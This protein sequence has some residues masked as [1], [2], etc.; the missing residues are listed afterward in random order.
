MRIVPII[1]A[2]LV[3]L[4]LVVAVLQRDAL[5]EFAANPPWSDTG[6][7]D[8][9]TQDAAVQ[10][11]SSDE[12]AARTDTGAAQDAQDGVIDGA[13]SVVAMRSVAQEIDSAVILRGETQAARQVDVRSETSATV[14]SEPLRKGA[15]VAAGEALC[16]LDPGTRGASLAEAQ[17][18]L[19][20]AQARAP[21]TEARI[22]EAE[23]RLAEARARL[24]EA[25]VNANAA[26]QL[27][28]DGFA[29]ETRVK[30]TEAA[31]KSAEASVSA[32][33]AGVKAARSGLDST[34][35]GIQSAEAAVAA[36]EKEIERLTITA[37]FDGILETDTAELGV[38][39]QPGSLCAN[40]LQL[41]PIKLVAFVPE[42]EVSRVSLGARAAARL[43]TGQEIAGR[44]SFLAR[45]ADPQT[46]T[47]RL[48]VEV[49]NPELA[50]RDGQTAEIIVS[51]PGA[52]AH[53]LPQSALTLNDDGALGV[54][55]V[56]PDELALFVPVTLLR[57]TREGVWV[58][59]LDT[60]ADVITL[61]QEYVTDGV[62]VAATFEEVM[63]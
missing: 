45:S 20:E 19:A 62:P 12:A 56:D 7:Q 51:A 13:V 3:T 41:D 36:A 55:V 59:G 29:S 42:T 4:F 22:P 28:Q 26:R 30:N 32:A 38:L 37:P 16:T 35:A 31:V 49:P 50:I 40:I 43:T 23:A 1:T 21:E 44:V 61:G 33:E 54:R 25:Q 39:L 11:A 47:F 8:T 63:Q 52:Q 46:R 14:I 10:D 15:F 9:G 17:A 18:R 48:E 27:L 2:A 6:S 24:D 58:T 34:S 5:K 57:D 53:L 60:E